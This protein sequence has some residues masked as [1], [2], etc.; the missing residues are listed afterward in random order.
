MAGDLRRYVSAF[1]LKNKL[2]YQ[3]EKEISQKEFASFV[4][5]LY[6]VNAP[7]LPTKKNNKKKT[8]LTQNTKCSAFWHW[9]LFPDFSIL[10]GSVKK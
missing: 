5:S 10:F 1:K 3:H 2:V 4:C 6:T 9:P 7:P 8:Y